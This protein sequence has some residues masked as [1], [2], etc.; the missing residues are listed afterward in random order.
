MEVQWQGELRV[1]ESVEGD[2]AALEGGERVPLDQLTVDGTVPFMPAAAFDEAWWEDLEQVPEAPEEIRACDR[3]ANQA[4][5]AVR[6]FLLRMETDQPKVAGLRAAAEERRRLRERDAQRAERL[7]TQ[8]FRLALDNPYVYEF[9]SGLD[10]PAKQPDVDDP[11]LLRAEAR[12]A[13]WLDA[14][15]DA[16]TLQ[17]A[18]WQTGGACFRRDG[19]PDPDCKWGS[20]R[21]ELPL[22]EDDLAYFAWLDVSERLGQPPL[23]MARPAKGRR[24]SLAVL[25]GVGEPQPRP[26]TVARAR[27]MLRHAERAQR[28]V[29]VATT[30]F[31]DRPE[32]DIVFVNGLARRL[33]EEVQAW[34]SHA[35]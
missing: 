16:V 8:V 33:R 27:L 28:A 20:K 3:V 24:L 18:A 31:P 13:E 23:A 7:E 5:D 10:V 17:Q 2:Q 11:E 22:T 9:A 26:D 34:L 6:T 14:Y 1:L 21:V 25:R 32:R 12:R 29:G 30:F 35:G 15:A 4:R 19:T